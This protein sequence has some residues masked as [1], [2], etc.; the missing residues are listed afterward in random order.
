VV[1]AFDGLDS[2]AGLKRTRGNRDLYVSLLKQFVMGF[3]AFGEELTLLVREGKFEDAQRLAHSL[4]GVAANVGADRV[5]DTASV[6]EQVLKRSEAAENAL[7][8]VERELKPVVA[9]LAE[10]L[11]I[12]ATMTTPPAGMTGTHGADLSDVT[13]PPWVDDLRRLMADGD[14]AAQQLWAERG[15]ELRDLLPP[16]VYA[17]VRRALDNFEF[18][19]ALAALATE[20]AGT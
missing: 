10:V 9:K 7:A 19:V 8:E 4:K 18:D 2:V 14:V 12:D 3:A 11:H 13:L 16:Q 6:L 1:P 20:K 17:H 15:E 5:A